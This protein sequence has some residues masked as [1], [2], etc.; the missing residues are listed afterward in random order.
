MNTY[1]SSIILNCDIK[2]IYLFISSIEFLIELIEP[3]TNI[4]Y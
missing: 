3:K 2:N 1:V 4:K